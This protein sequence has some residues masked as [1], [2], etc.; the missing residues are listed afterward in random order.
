MSRSTQ[1]IISGAVGTVATIK[2]AGIVLKELDGMS[3][4]SYKKKNSKK[5]Y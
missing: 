4:S 5:F 2:V 1:E 3:K